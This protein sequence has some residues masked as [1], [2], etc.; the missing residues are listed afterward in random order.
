MKG[1]EPAVAGVR[2]A[3]ASAVQTRKS[4]AARDAVAG[5]L[6]D[7]WK[8][9]LKVGGDPLFSRETGESIYRMA[10]DA[11]L[12]ARMGFAPG[13]LL[14]EALD[15]IVPQ[16]GGLGSMLG[17][18]PE[19]VKKLTLVKLPLADLTT[20]DVALALAQLSHTLKGMGR[21][22][23]SMAVHGHPEYSRSM[24]SVTQKAFK[25]RGAVNG[26]FLELGFTIDPRELANGYSGKEAE[27]ERF[28]TAAFEKLRSE[29]AKGVAA[30]NIAL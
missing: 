25:E 19:N 20:G 16:R 29:M 2:A 22:S 26:D 4:N 21:D 18:P 17:R 14:R 27:V 15:N 23:L 8:A 7:A 1:I 24:F 13:A 3:I 10:G 6:S 9:P 11:G 30:S 12:Q 28:V 5:P